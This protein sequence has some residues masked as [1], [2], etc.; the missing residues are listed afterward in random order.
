MLMSLGLFVFEAATLMPNELS[1]RAAWEHPS[2]ERIGARPAYQF[3]GPAE[4]TISI[5]ARLVPEMGNRPGAIDTLRSMAD[6]GDDYQLVDGAGTVFGAFRITGID[7]T[8]R[9]LIDN[10][11]PRIIDFTINLVRSG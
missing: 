4:E 10:G 2:N 5:P 11:L 9:E 1:R 6:Q 8:R 3:T 7:D